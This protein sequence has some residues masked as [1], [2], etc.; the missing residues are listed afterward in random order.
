MPELTCE[1]LAMN[2]NEPITTSF[3]CPK[4]VRELL[5]ARC[6]VTKTSLSAYIVEALTEKLSREKVY[7]TEKELKIVK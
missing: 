6:E 4:E 3:R 7:V 5:E 2:P 1:T